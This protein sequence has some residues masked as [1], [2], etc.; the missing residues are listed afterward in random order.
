VSWQVVPT[1]LPE[2]ISDPD[3]DKARKANAPMMQMK[4]RTSRRCAA[5]P[6]ELAIHSPL[7]RAKV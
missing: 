7:A 3:A 4:N 6:D 5:P 2:L 1:I